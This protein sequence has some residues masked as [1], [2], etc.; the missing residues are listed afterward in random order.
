MRTPANTRETIA[1]VSKRDTERRPLLTLKGPRPEYADEADIDAQLTA[2]RKKHGLPIVAP[3][4]GLPHRRKV[5]LG[6]VGTDADGRERRRGT[7]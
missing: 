6:R 1:P 4:F 5:Q 7:R 3:Q 2:G